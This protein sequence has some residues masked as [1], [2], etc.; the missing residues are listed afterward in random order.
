MKKTLFFVILVSLVLVAVGGIVYAWE[1]T[2]E[3]PPKSQSV[4]TISNPLSNKFSNLGEL[5]NGF[6][7]IVAYLL[8][9]IAVLMIIWTGF[10][11]ITAQGKPER[12]KELSSRM[13][14]I[15]LGIA[16]VIGARL[17]VNIVINTLESSGA[18]NQST[19][20]AARDA[21]NSR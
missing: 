18:V 6:A 5:I 19:I 17:I 15:V 13:G 7:D 20:N 1:G 10:Q 11:F 2:T 4:F 16:I 8:I 14:F 21:A 9:I 12:L 3:D